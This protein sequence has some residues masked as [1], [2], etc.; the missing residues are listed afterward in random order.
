ML[1]AAACYFGA[2]G[3]VGHCTGW[4]GWVQGLC[5]MGVALWERRVGDGAGDIWL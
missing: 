5:E 4:V 1:G 2:V 3:W